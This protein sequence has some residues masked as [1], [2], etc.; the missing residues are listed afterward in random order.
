MIK[1]RI[2]KNGAVIWK[3]TYNGRTLYF[4]NKEYPEICPHIAEVY[5]KTGM[6][7]HWMN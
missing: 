2:A 5:A 4:T 6:V 7:C 1:R 3:A